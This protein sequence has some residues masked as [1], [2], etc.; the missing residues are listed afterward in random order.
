MKIWESIV[1]QSIKGEQI[2]VLICNSL[3]E[4]ERLHH[5]LTIDA[6]EFKKNIAEVKPEID[7]LSTGQRQESGKINW[8]KDFIELPKWYD[9]N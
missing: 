1:I 5:F 6:Y 7:Y 3:A 9:L 2:L 8:N 4:Q